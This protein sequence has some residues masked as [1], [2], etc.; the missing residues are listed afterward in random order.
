VDGALNCLFSDQQVGMQLGAL[1]NLSDS[2]CTV[3][4]SSPGFSPL[5]C[6]RNAT[7]ADLKAG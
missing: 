7:Y 2:M 6:A 5:L 1:I 3:Q 4:G